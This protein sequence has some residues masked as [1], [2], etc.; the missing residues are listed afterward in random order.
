MATTLAILKAGAERAAD[1]AEAL[2]D[3]A[4]DAQTMAYVRMRAV[5]ARDAATATRGKYARD[6][7]DEAAGHLAAAKARLAS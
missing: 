3:E 2:V 5:W 7:A 1:E 4:T 6:H